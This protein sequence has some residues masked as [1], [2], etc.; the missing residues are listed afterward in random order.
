MATLLPYALCTVSDVKE[1][2]GISS[3]DS[4]HDSLIIRK[5]NQATDMIETYTGR[6][7]ALTTYTNEQYD[8]TRTDQIILKQRPV[9]ALTAFGRRDTLLNEDD[10]ETI[11][12]QLYFLDSDAGVLDL[13][14]AA[15]GQWNGWQFTYTAG[16]TTI[17]AA[18]AESAA[19]LAA[20]LVSNPIAAGSSVR[21][22]EEGQRRIEYYQVGGSGSGAGGNG[23]MDIVGITSILDSYSNMPVLADK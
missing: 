15:G 13:L 12:S 7:F 1:N 9:T 2:L 22:K 5:I 8:G 14:F 4:S 19:S 3:S 11:D 20:Y 23:I 6:R 10:F 16:Y 17:P 18:I 21:T